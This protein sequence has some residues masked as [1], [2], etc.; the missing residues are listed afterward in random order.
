LTTAPSVSVVIPTYNNGAFV[1]SAVESASHQELRPAEIIV[2]DDGS[3]DGTADALHRYR[4]SIRYITQPNSGPAVARNRGVAAAHSEWIAFLDADDVW[5]PH[6]LQQQVQCMEANPSAGLIHSAFLLW[7]PCTDERQPPNPERHKFAG[8]CYPYFFF[9]NGVLPSTALVRK[10]CVDA[11]GG[12]DE[13]IRKAGVEDYD[14]GFRIARHCEFAYIEEPLVLYRRHQQNASKQM[15]H[16]LDGQIRV[17]MKALCEDP[18]LRTLLD[19]A[20]YHERMHDLLSHLGYLYHN[21]GLNS[22]ARNCFLRATQHRPG[23]LYLWLLYLANLL[24]ARWIRELRSLK[25]SIR[26]RKFR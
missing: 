13:S 21:E 19:D 23:D 9:G 1:A 16:M 15:V 22:Q 3:T 20:D 7:D 6:K 10:E 14:F 12:F 26:A 4:E 25:S 18:E 17:I 5:L 8:R 11:I 2:V 24:P